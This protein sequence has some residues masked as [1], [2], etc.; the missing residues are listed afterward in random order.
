[1]LDREHLRPHRSAVRAPYRELCFALIFA[2]LF[3][4]VAHA[5]QPVHLERLGTRPVAITATDVFAPL[6]AQRLE[7]SLCGFAV[8]RN[9]GR[10]RL[11]IRKSIYGLVEY[12]RE[13]YGVRAGNDRAALN[14]V[15]LLPL[16]VDAC[17]IRMLAVD[18]RDRRRGAIVPLTIA[19]A[20]VLPLLP[21]APGARLESATWSRVMDGCIDGRSDRCVVYG[22]WRD[23]W[24]A[25]DPRLWS[26]PPHV[27]R[28]LE[29]IT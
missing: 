5:Q 8:S 29:W 24:L 25:T 3:T 12:P 7:P 28:G 16:L 14:G 20:E 9:A 22:T 17:E 23:V 18:P 6:D 26:T 4:R 1:V 27:V 2:Q 13:R 10:D 19:S 15:W 11:E 21:A